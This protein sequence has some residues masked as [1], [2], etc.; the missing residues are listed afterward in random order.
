MNTGH[1]GVWHRVNGRYSITDGVVTVIVPWNKG[2]GRYSAV[3]DTLKHLNTLYSKSKVVKGRRVC[4]LCHQPLYRHHKFFFRPDGRLQ[5]HR[6]D[7][8]EEYQ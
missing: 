1:N 5:H 7:A 8:P 6:C 4:G 3:E 2:R